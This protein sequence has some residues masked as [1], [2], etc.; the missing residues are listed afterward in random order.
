M[1][2]TLLNIAETLKSHLEENRPPLYGLKGGKSETSQELMPRQD[3]LPIIA[4]IPLELSPLP[5]ESKSPS[6]KEAVSSKVE[7]PLRTETPLAK[8]Q[9]RE[10]PT[11]KQP[12]LAKAPS[13]LKPLKIDKEIDT[14]SD[15]STLFHSSF[16]HIFVHTDIPSDRKAIAIKT[17]WKIKSR[18][19]DVPIFST[20]EM[21]PFLPLLH[22]IAKAISASFAPSKVI[23]IDTVEKKDVWDTLLDSHYIKLILCPDVILWS[24]KALMK[25]YKQQPL[26]TVQKLGDIDLILLP[27]LSLYLKD[28]MLKQALWN[29]LSQYF[30]QTKK[31]EV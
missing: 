27:E 20:Q 1:I 3:S 22:N 7:I 16:P 11:P 31:N 18:L 25:H 14:L 28:P 5:I 4:K 29:M 17:G 2:D 23:H 19:I 10:E 6:K 26:K 15:I 24:S 12:P 8:P 9:M 30:E 21:T 13:P